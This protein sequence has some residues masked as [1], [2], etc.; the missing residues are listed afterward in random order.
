[1]A[2]TLGL[3]GEPFGVG[4][5]TGVGEEDAEADMELKQVFQVECLAGADDDEGDEYTYREPMC[6]AVFS[7]AAHFDDSSKDLLIVRVSSAGLESEVGEPRKVDAYTVHIPVTR[8]NR[9]DF[10][11]QLL[12][13][14]SQQR[15][16]ALIKET[17]QNLR[18]AYGDHCSYSVLNRAFNALVPTRESWIICVRV[19]PPYVFAHMKGSMTFKAPNAV[20]A[21]VTFPLDKEEPK[22][23]ERGR[24]INFTVDVGEKDAN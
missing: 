16:E 14:A 15:R 22:I 4:V 18:Q 9:D 2:K 23:D 13:M 6:G 3:A 1:V 5:A 21:M 24:T 17:D 8:T 19:K 10:V 20:D 11:H 12:P 7:P